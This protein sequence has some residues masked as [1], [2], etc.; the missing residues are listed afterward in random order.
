MEGIQLTNKTTPPKGCLILIIFG[1]HK[2]AKTKNIQGLFRDIICVFFK[3][4][5]CCILYFMLTKYKLC[6]T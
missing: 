2:S 4:Q 6:Y 5:N 3:D 1:V